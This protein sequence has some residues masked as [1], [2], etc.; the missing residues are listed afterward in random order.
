MVKY[1][2]ITIGLSVIF[3]SCTIRPPD[4]YITSEKTALENQLFGEG[5][6]LSKTQITTSAVWA[7]LLEP[8]SNE[9][10]VE[11]MDGDEQHLDRQLILSQ[12]RR[13]SMQ[14]YIDQLKRQQLIGE[15]NDGYVRIVSD[16][17]KSNDELILIVEAENKD[18]EVIW[19]SYAEI[20]GSD[21]E[22]ELTAIQKKF[23]EIVAGLS[24]S[25]TWIQNYQ[26]EWTIK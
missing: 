17:M 18:R 19:K 6:D 22:N 26:N 15:A 4:V 3:L 2:F 23:A 7:A 24:P 10:V 25:G 14:P 9:S 13:Q 5:W 16:D 1:I 12:I 21:S 8:S 20:Q 11:T